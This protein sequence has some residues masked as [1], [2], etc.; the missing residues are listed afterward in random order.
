VPTW[1]RA[2]RSR[3]SDELSGSGYDEGV[4]KGAVVVVVQTPCGRVVEFAGLGLVV[5]LA[6]SLGFG[7]LGD[8]SFVIAN[9]QP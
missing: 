8:R 5:L 9:D 6:R 7:L 1:S 4:E 2:P 3:F